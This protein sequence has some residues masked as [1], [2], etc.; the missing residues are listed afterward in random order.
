MIFSIERIQTR[1]ERFFVCHLLV[2]SLNIF[3]K[4]NPRSVKIIKNEIKTMKCNW[5]SSEMGRKDLK[6]FSTINSKKLLNDAAAAEIKI[7][8]PVVI[9]HFVLG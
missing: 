4:P 2:T 6:K 3:L 9:N 7:N 5:I 1:L 8:A